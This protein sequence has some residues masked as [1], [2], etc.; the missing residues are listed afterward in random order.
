MT[1]IEDA[2]RLHNSLISDKIIEIWQRLL[3]RSPIFVDDDFFDLG[4]NSLI[5][6]RLFLDIEREIGRSL[7]ITTIYEAPTVAKLAA[8][9]GGAAAPRFS[10]LVLLKDGDD[11]APLFIAHGLGGNVMELT[12]L[13]KRIQ[14]PHPVY[15]IQ[16]RG[17]DGEGAPCETIEEMG[18]IY[19]AAIREVQP[20][21]PYYLAGYSFGGLVALEIAHRLSREGEKIAFLGFLDS[22]PN[23]QYWPLISRLTVLRRLAERRVAAL[24]KSPIRSVGSAALNW[25]WSLARRLAVPVGHFDRELS[26]EPSLPLPVREVFQSAAL[27]WRAYRPRYYSGKITFFK[28]AAFL[29]Y[30]E[31][32]V[33]VWRDLAD[34]FELHVVPGDHRA[35][36]R[37]QAEA[38]AGALGTCLRRAHD[39]A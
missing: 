1:T 26:I 30:P 21:G 39:Q 6:T 14:S 16:A 3:Q 33:R 4:G 17:L 34:E 5:L 25:T 35:L 37:E 36:V 24:L 18:R 23:Q 22:Y 7:P 31:N 2:T 38:L 20:H 10:P 28:A 9:V 12:L 27:A 8:V 32:P 11:G 29:V 19:V 13:G 15:A